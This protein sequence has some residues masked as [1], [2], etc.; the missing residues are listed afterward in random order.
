MTKM[1][2]PPSTPKLHLL[3]NQADET[4]KAP[5]PKSENWSKSSD[6]DEDFPR[7]LSKKSLYFPRFFQ[8][9]PIFSSISSKTNT[10]F[11]TLL[12]S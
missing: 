9:K 11:A 4:K 1:T 12:L 3:D 10:F 8:K 5:S 7:F 2:T 6:K